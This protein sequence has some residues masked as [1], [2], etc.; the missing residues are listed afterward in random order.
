[1]NIRESALR[2]V[3]ITQAQD[4]Y[5]NNRTRQSAENTLPLEESFGSVLNREQ[6]LHFSG[7][8][9]SRLQS[10]GIQMTDLQMKRL[11]SAKSQA[12]E[13]GIRE[14]LIMLDNL[15]FIVNVPSNTVITAMDR[16]EHENKVFTN[17]DGAVIA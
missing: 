11:N 10:R 8:A 16:D 17:I 1:M 9:G 13:K 7:R 3:S 15:A 12:Q 4:A 2:S 6:E 5:R 14:S